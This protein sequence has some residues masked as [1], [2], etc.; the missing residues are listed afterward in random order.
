MANRKR[1]PDSPYPLTRAAPARNGK[2]HPAYAGRPRGVWYPDLVGVVPGYP[3]TLEIWQKKSDICRARII[4]LNASD[5]PPTRAGVPDGW[6]GAKGR[7][8]RAAVAAGPRSKEI[9]DAMIDK[10]MVKDPDDERVVKA[11]TVTVEILE[12]KDEETFKPLYTAKDR[13]SAA[14]LLCDF[15][16]AKPASKIEASVT[17]AEDFLAVLAGGLNQNG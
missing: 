1:Q 5:N 10:G 2:R 3:K 11:L 6:A 14:R 8:L 4:A 17:K 9:V 15:L 16:K 13:L 7:A 12:A